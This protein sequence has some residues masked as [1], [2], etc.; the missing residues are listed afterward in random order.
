MK[1]QTIFWDLFVLKVV[2]INHSGN[3]QVSHQIY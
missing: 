2:S 3:C 1:H